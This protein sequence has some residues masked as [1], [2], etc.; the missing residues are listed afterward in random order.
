MIMPSGFTQ[1]CIVKKPRASEE[2]FPADVFPK[3]IIETLPGNGIT[4]DCSLSD[5]MRNEGFP[6]GLLQI[7]LIERGAQHIEVPEALLEY[8]NDFEWWINLVNSEDCVSALKELDAVL[9]LYNSR[10]VTDLDPQNDLLAKFQ[11]QTEEC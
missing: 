1:L 3:I 9:K 7:G 10:F 8:A 11:C 5:T 6:D 4:L 2:Q